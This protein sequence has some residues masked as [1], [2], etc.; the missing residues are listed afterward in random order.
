MKEKKVSKNLLALIEEAESVID[1]LNHMSY[2]KK[3]EQALIDSHLNKL[4]LVYESLNGNTASSLKL[5]KGTKTFL[6]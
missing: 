1:Q 4:D 2:N 6:Q 3:E 5:E